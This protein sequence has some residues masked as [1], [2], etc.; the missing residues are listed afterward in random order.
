MLIKKEL[1]L[2]LVY[3]PFLNKLYTATKNG[4]AF[5]NGQPIHTK[6]S[7]KTLDKALL[8]IEYGSADDEKKKNVVFSNLQKF[9]WKCHGIRQF[10]SAA[11]NLCHVA[12]GIFGSTRAHNFRNY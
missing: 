3:S 1:V 5:L 8:I 9:L 2:G 6:K 10:G 11:L 12:E 4:G 7:T